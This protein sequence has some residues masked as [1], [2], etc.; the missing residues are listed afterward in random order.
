MDNL[1]YYSLFSILSIYCYCLIV[2]THEFTSSSFALFYHFPFVLLSFCWTVSF[3]SQ[4][5]YF[6]LLLPLSFPFNFSY[7][8]TFFFIFYL[9]NILCPPLS[10]CLLSC[11]SNLLLSRVHDCAPFNI[12]FIF[13]HSSYSFITSFIFYSIIF[14][15]IFLY[16]PYL[17]SCS[18]NVLLSLVPT[19]VR[20][21][22]S[23]LSFHF[24][25]LR[26]FLIFFIFYLTIPFLYLPLSALFA[27]LFSQSSFS[28]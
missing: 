22:T 26:L 14:F 21:L 28:C 7:S 20:L 19:M 24:F 9:N 8:F 12:F 1:Q 3:P 4:I 18:S 11:S 6:Y 15:F 10:S 13:F 17:P 23:S 16:L 5:S 2:I 27:L 25:I